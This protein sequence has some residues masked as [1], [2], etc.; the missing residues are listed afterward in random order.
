MIGIPSIQRRSGRGGFTLV[1]LLIGTLIAAIVITVAFQVLVG[2]RRSAEARREEMN[3]QQNLRVSID[4]LTRDLRMAGFGVDEF[5]NQPRFLDAGPWQ[6]AFN[7]DITSGVGGDPAMDSTMQ[8]KLTG[9]A[10][11][12]AGDYPGE[13]LGA[14]RR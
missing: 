5:L 11:Y 6:V 4:R 3:A 7:G 1:E 2:E 10:T 14:E 13:I 8:I 9:G 12:S